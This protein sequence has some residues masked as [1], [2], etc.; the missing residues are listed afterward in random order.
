MSTCTT[1]L[2]RFPSAKVLPIVTFKN[3]I[4]TPLSCIYVPSAHLVAFHI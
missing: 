4:A 3:A 2:L 1:L